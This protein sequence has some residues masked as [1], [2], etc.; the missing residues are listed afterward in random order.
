ME[1]IFGQSEK[2]AELAAKKIEGRYWKKVG[3]GPCEAI[4]V[5]TGKD[6]TAKLLAICVY[7]DYFPQ[8]ATCMV[9]ICAWSPQW[10]QKGI[11]KELLSIP[12]D[13]YGVKK[14]CATI[15]QKN[16]RA[17]GF[18]LG[19]GFKQEAVLRNQLGPNK[20]LCFTYLMEP[21]FRRIYCRKK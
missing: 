20:H 5:A 4:G 14:L 18:N 8:Y 7:H 12:F 17:L 15:P 13:K 21:E 1:L 6:A 16:A 3:F 9:S 19:L 10:A 11:I 2:L